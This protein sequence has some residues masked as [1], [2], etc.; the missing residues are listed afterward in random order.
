MIKIIDAPAELADASLVGHKFA[1]QQH[2]RDAGISV[3]PFF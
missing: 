1:H 3:P 2:M